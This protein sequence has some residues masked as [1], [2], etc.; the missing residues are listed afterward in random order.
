MSAAGSCWK[1]VLIFTCISANAVAQQGWASA[2]LD[3]KKLDF[4]VIATGSEAIETLKVTNNLASTVQLS[5]VSTGCQCA[6]AMIVGP[7]QLAPN[8]STTIEVRINTLAYTR[9]RETTLTIG[10]DAPSFTTVEVP[11]EA[12]IRTDVVFDPGKLD[13]GSV[14][15]GKGAEQ[16]VKVTYAGRPTWTIVG[17]KCSDPALK[18]EARV[19]ARNDPAVNGINVEYSLRFQLSAEARA[20]RFQ[21]YV[22]LETD[23]ASNPY[24]PLMVQ[25]TVLPDFSI[26]NPRIEIKALRPGQTATVRVVVRGIRPFVVSGVDCGGLEECF[27]VR[28]GEVPEK[29][30]VVDMQFTAPARPGRFTEKMQLKVEGREQS[31]EFSVSG[32]ILN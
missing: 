23:D 29:L 28:K 13:F 24:I 26:S 18:C 15:F 27:T 25:G 11:I 8:Q 30:Q 17:V 31:L 22:T 14:E 19:V 3:R 7:R 6:S 12:Y 9:K 21:E 1:A 5:G 2:L 32:V 20:G 4:G 16:S 10:F